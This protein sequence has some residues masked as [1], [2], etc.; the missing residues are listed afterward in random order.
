MKLHKKNNIFI[1]KFISL[2]YPK[3]FRNFKMIKCQKKLHTLRNL[4]KCQ[5]VKKFKKANWQ[6][7]K[8]ANWQNSMMAK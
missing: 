8:M 7:V 5:N 4:N 6:N 3:Y 2:I 1:S